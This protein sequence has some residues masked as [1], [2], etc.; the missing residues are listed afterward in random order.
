VQDMAVTDVHC[1]FGIR[2]TF[3]VEFS[4]G[5]NVRAGHRR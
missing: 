1:I 5:A 3:A 2:L 4:H